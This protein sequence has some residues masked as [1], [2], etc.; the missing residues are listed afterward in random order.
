[1]TGL[2]GMRFMV[3]AMPEH[4]GTFTER[5]RHSTRL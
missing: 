2:A 5:L 4:G 3:L 1:M